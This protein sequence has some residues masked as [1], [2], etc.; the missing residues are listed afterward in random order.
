MGIAVAV[1][2][3]LTWASHIAKRPKATDRPPALPAHMFPW[4]GFWHHGIDL[5]V[6]MDT[7]QIHVAIAADVADGLGAKALRSTAKGAAHVVGVEIA[8]SVTANT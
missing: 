6:A 8:D 1:G 2:S 5:H 7:S 4:L 3:K